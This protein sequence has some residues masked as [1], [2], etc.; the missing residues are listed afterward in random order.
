MLRRHKISICISLSLIALSSATST[1][2]AAPPKPANPAIQRSA[3]LPVSDFADPPLFSLAA[4]ARQKGEEHIDIGEVCKTLG[5]TND[6]GK[7]QVYQLSYDEPSLPSF[8]VLEATPGQT[9][10]VII[11]HV[12]A[13]VA[14][15]SQYAQIYLTGLD[16][17]LRGVAVAN[18]QGNDQ[19][20]TWSTFS[21]TDSKVKDEFAREI[22]FWQEHVKDLNSRP[23]PKH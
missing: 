10:I 18:K 17:K 21:I 19:A 3:P 16:G 14:D 12:R 2:S 22:S 5:V 6:I 20:W 8:N 9:I 23:D 7:C 1:S 11:R 15:K 4:L 13:S